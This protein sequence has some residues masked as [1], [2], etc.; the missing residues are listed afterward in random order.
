MTRARLLLARPS[1]QAGFTIVEMMVALAISFIVI[2]GFAVTFVNIKST[3]V[4]QDKV[5][6]LQDNERLAMSILTSAAQEAGYF[7]F[8]TTLDASQIVASSDPTYGSM[9]AG[10]LVYGTSYSA[11]PAAPESLSLAFAASANDGLITCQGH[12]IV[13]S[14]ISGAPSPANNSVGVRHIFYVDTANKTLN[15]IAMVNG[16]TGSAYGGGT[17]QPLVTNVASMSVLYGVIGSSGLTTSVVGYYPASGVTNWS[18]V[19]SV[20][21]TLNFVNPNDAT[22]TIPW[23]Q[24][25]NL[26]N[27]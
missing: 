2:L 14:D 21:I 23:V 4:G 9:T 15:C 8:P 25:I 5:S 7:P 10:Q 11:S 3:F 12:T 24:T 17:T 19:K 27:R 13:A 6:Q 22:A 20:R 16:N 26:L 1:R 18:N